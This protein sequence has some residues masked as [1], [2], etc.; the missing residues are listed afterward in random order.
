MVWALLLAF[1]L[2]PIIEIYVVIRVGQVIGPFPTIG[3]LIIES[4]L[5]AWLVK[6]EGRRAW[7]EQTREYRQR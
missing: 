6:R 7:L 2:T 1:L 4:L 5:G 3:L